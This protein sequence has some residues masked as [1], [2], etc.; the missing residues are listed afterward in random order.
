MEFA[1]QVQAEGDLTEPPYAVPDRGGVV[2]D[3]LDIVPRPL[4]W[5]RFPEEHLGDRRLGSFDPR[6][7]DRLAS[8]CSIDQKVRFGEDAAQAVERTDRPL[9]LG[10]GDDGLP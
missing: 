5:Q 10:Q 6:A 7:L 9:G 1:Y 4:L 2:H 3:L 8:H